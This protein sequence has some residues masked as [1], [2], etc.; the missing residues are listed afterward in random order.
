M[1]VATFREKFGIIEQKLLVDAGAAVPMMR[2]QDNPKVNCV[3]IEEWIGL[4]VKI[5]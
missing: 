2:M 3:P 1:T 4:M 5:V